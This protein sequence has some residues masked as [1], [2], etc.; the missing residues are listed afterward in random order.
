MI[1]FWK[2]FYSRDK[3]SWYEKLLHLSICH[4]STSVLTDKVSSTDFSLLS[5]SIFKLFGKNSHRNQQNFGIQNHDQRQHWNKNDSVKQSNLKLA[6]Q[7]WKWTSVE[8]FFSNGE[9]FL[10]RAFLTSRGLKAQAQE[11]ELPMLDINSVEIPLL[12][13]EIQFGIYNFSN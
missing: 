5:S 9:I 1:L 11:L 4:S 8:Q 12:N 3:I 6:W 7:N 13:S 2:Q 10:K